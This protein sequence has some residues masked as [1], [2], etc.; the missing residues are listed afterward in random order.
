MMSLAMVLV[1]STVV[2]SDIIGKGMSPFQGTALR[3]G[4]ACV[5]FGLIWLVRSET[6][7]KLDRSDWFV[8]VLQSFL[9]SFVFS[10]LLIVGLY[11]TAGANAGVV[12]GTLPVVMALMAFVVFRERLETG[13]IV[14][15]ALATLAI[16]LVTVVEAS[17]STP[18]IESASGILSKDYR[19]VLGTGIL[20]LA[21]LCEAIFLLLNRKLKVNVPAFQLA[22]M[23]SAFG[24]AFGIVGATIEF[25][26]ATPPVPS[27]AA[28]W[29]AIYYGVVPTL[30]GFP[31]WYGGSSRGTALDASLCTAIV[32]VAAVVL[33]AI[34][35]DE[36]VS[37]VQTIA[38]AIIVFS[39]ILGAVFS[40]RD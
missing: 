31:L 35:L 1:G 20:L 9:G 32:P 5:G 37:T 15:I 29:G 6:L 8:V 11:F 34:I 25:W 23:M 14:A 26:I 18:S 36:T 38:C 28:I 33:S 17:N 13:S 7:P 22:A 40:T 16:G 27:T 10:I 39:I 3:F 30:I 21:V 12:V 19:V 2:A 24:F 4:V